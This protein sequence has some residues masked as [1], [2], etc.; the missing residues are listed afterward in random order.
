MNTAT[1]DHPHARSM[2]Q[3]NTFSHLRTAYRRFAA[4]QQRRAA[5]QDLRSLDNRMLKDIGL[6]RSEIVSAV[7]GIR[8]AHD[9]KPQNLSQIE[10]GNQ[11]A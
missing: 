11:K 7:Y 10:P 5:V 3:H 8:V 4:W 9:R 6:D 2:R 1:H